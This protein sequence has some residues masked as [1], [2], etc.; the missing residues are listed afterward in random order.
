MESSKRRRLQLEHGVFAA[1]IQALPGSASGS[2]EEDHRFDGGSRK[3]KER[4]ACK[5]GSGAGFC[6]LQPGVVPSDEEFFEMLSEVRGVKHVEWQTSKT[7]QG[8]PSDG[9]HMERNILVTSAQPGFEGYRI[10]FELIWNKHMPDAKAPITVTV[11]FKE[12]TADLIPEAWRILTEVVGDK[13]LFPAIYNQVMENCLLRHSRRE[14]NCQ[15]QGQVRCAAAY[16]LRAVE[17]TQ[18][19]GSA[20]GH[21]AACAQQ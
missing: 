4:F 7:S 10:E 13:A 20:S 3:L 17:R 8:N 6:E 18:P 16:P 21:S 19:S 9:R 1:A 15:Q 5:D 2:G 14:L 11:C 12:P